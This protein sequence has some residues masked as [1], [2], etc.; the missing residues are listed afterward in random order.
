MEDL[1]LTEAPQYILYFG[2]S[3]T[4]LSLVTSF[5]AFFCA[6][7]FPRGDLDEIRALIESVSVSF[8][9]F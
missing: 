4:W 1:P 9:T 8:Y 5:M 7:F 2:N 3:M 6:V